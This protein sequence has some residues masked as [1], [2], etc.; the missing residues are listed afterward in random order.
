MCVQLLL[1]KAKQLGFNVCLAAAY[2]AGHWKI[3]PVERKVIVGVGIAQPGLEG[4]AV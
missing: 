1:R 2:T 4:A 3:R